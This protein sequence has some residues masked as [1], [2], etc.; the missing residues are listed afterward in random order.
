MKN[1]LTFALGLFLVLN[2]I[3]IISVFRNPPLEI[4]YDEEAVEPMPIV[5]NTPHAHLAVGG[6]P[7]E[8]RNPELTRWLSAGLKIATEKGS[9]SGTIIYYDPKDNYAYVQSCGHLWDSNMTASEARIRKPKCQV[10]TWY[11]NSKKLDVPKKYEAEI[12]YCNNVRG[13]DCSLLRFHPDWI[14]HYFPIA[15]DEFKYEASMMLHSVG[16]DSGKEVAHYSVRF[17]SL[18]RGDVITTEN[19]PRPGRSGGGLLTKRLYVGICWGTTDVSG[20]G[21][22]LFTPL[23]VLRELNEKN[24]YG[25]LNELGGAEIRKIPIID[26]TNPDVKHPFDHIPLPTSHVPSN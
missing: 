24:G 1:L 10:I 12:L 25:W 21:N 17:L 4:I 7:V 14:P 6:V 16:C 5:L 2:T 3:L 20:N 18:Y 23:S 9:G 26:H 22:G 8:E 11:H 19:S 13:Q 15:P